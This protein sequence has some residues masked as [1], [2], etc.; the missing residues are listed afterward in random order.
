VRLHA[1]LAE[2]EG[3]AGVPFDEDIVEVDGGLLFLGLV[4]E[5]VGAEGA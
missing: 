1:E 2:E 4:L 5:G 3:V